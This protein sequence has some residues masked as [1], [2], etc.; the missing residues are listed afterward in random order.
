[1]N[2]KDKLIRKL[3]DTGKKHRILVYPTLALVAVISAISHAVYWGRGNGKK[4]VASIM[5]MTMLITQSLFLTSSADVGDNPTASGDASPTDAVVM[6]IEDVDVVSEPEIG[7]IIRLYRIDETGGDPIPLESIPVD[8]DNPTITIPGATELS[9]YLFGTDQTEYVNFSQVYADKDMTIPVSGAID[10]S[11][12]DVLN[13]NNGEYSLFFKATRTAY[14]FVIKDDPNGEPAIVTG[15]PHAPITIKAPATYTEGSGDL[16]PPMSYTVESS[17]SGLERFGYNFAGLYY[18][19]GV[20]CTKDGESAVININTDESNQTTVTT[21]EAFS[22]WSPIPVE[23]TFDATPVGAPVSLA[24]ADGVNDNGE[25]TFTY[26]FG[27]TINII[28]DAEIWASNEAYYLSGWKEVESDGVT[29]TGTTYA[30]GSEV[31]TSQMVADGASMNTAGTAYV[32]RRYEAI[33]TYKTIKL[34]SDSANA[35]LNEDGSLS[36]IGTYGDQ[37]SNCNITAEY[38]NGEQSAQGTKFKY[39]IANLADVSTMLQKYGLFIAVDENNGCTITGELKD[40]TDVDVSFTLTVTDENVNADSTQGGEERVSYHTVRIVS[41]PK[42]ITIN[43]SAIVDLSGNQPNKVYDGTRDISIKTEATASGTVGTDQIV[44]LLNSAATIDDA[45]AGN[46]D[47][48]V[49]VEGMKCTSVTSNPEE[50]LERYTIVTDANNQITFDDRAIVERKP[51]SVEISLA[52]GQNST[53]LFGEKTP[54][55]V[56]KVTE[57]DVA[58]LVGTDATNYAAISTEAGYMSFMEQIL[59]F[60]SWTT[61]RSIYSNKGTYSVGAHFVPDG[62]NYA[63]SVVNAPTF[64][65]TRDAGVK[66]NENSADTAN[67][68]FSTEKL[69]NGYYPGLTIT[70]CGYYDKIRPVTDGD[71]T[72]DMSKETAEAKFYSDSNS[73]SAL[74]LGDL[75]NATISFQMLNS[76]TGAISE[77][78]TISGISVDTSAPILKN[79][80]VSPYLEYFNEFSFGS[81]FHSQEIDGE[82]VSSISIKVQYEGT[83]S[84]PDKLYYYFVDEA[85]ART[86]VNIY[87]KKL[88]LNDATGYYE[89]SILIGPTVYGQLVVYASDTTGNISGESTLSVS[90]Q[91]E[92]IEDYVNDGSTMTYFEWM[93]EN[94]SADANITTKNLIGEIASVSTEESKVWYNGLQLE[95]VATDDLEVDSGVNRIEWTV[96]K[97]DGTSY[98]VTENAGDVVASVL[99]IEDYGKIRSYMFTHTIQGEELPV[100]YYTISAVVYDNAGNSS[101]IDAVGPYLV[102]SQKPVITD[103]TDIGTESYLSGVTFEFTVS[104]DEAETVED[105]DN[106]G[107][108]GIQ[109]VTLYK[110]DA[111]GLTELRT[112]GVLDEYAYNITVNGTYVVEACDVAGNIATYEKTFNGISDTPPETPTITVEGTQGRNGWYIGNKPYIT[113]N[114]TIDIDGIPVVTKYSTE[115]GN[116]YIQDGFTNDYYEFQLEQEGEVTVSAWAVSASGVTSVETD[117]EVVK[118]DL[119]APEVYI[120]E[121]AVLEDGSMTV[122][123]RATD[124]VSGVDSTRVLLNDLPLDVTVED[125][126]LSGNFTAYEG[127]TYTITVEDIAGNVSEPL[128]FAPLSLVEYPVTD[129]TTSGAYLEAE[130]HIGTYPV[131][132]CYIAYKKATDADYTAALF[133]KVETEYG[134]DL[135]C[136]FR[137][138]E[139]DTVYDYKIYVKTDVSGEV[140]TIEG[141]FKTSSKTAT[142]VIYGSA[143]YDAN[144]ANVNAE[145][146]IYVSLYEANTIIASEK[147][148]NNTETTYMFKNVPNGSYRVVATDG[149][150]T[151]TS[152]VTVE[153]GGIVYPTDYV[154]TDG[155][156][157]VLNGKSTS[158]VIEDDSINITADELESIYDN[159]LYEGIITAEDE[160][161]LAAGGS[162]NVTLYASYMDVSDVSDAEM[163]VFDTKISDSAII[164]RYIQLYVVKEVRDYDGDLVNNTPALV[165]ELYY[166][167]TISFPL[168]DLAGEEIYVASVHGTGNSYVFKDWKNADD[169]TLSTNYVTITTRYF[170]VYALYRT[171]EKPTTYTVKWIDGDGKVMKTETVESGKAATPPAETPTKKATEKYTYKFS[172]WDKDY[173]CITTDTVISAWFTAHEIEPEEPDEPT[174]EEPD[175]PTTE[176]PD[177]PTTE[178]TDT[179]TTEEPPKDADVDDTGT[180]EPQY[181]YMGSADSPKT[182]DATPIVILILAMVMSSA[183]MIIFKKKFEE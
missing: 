95:V 125:G 85:G 169:V 38:I 84:S 1:M 76:T 128:E 15:T 147:L 116:K 131:S 17:Y 112:W 120:V 29:A 87:E 163:S 63:V 71:I 11:T 91:K 150:Y 126:V 78:V 94:S 119:D 55:Y 49:T 143:V 151:K 33:W 132:D 148:N 50:I 67:Y 70:P 178:D 22:H 165:P 20:Y 34:A 36:I 51:I 16:Y 157:F 153:N 180:Q 45:N 145:Y 53:V 43:P 41:N 139:T 19:G 4:L 9:S 155:I 121:S 28:A 118:V 123:F 97:A 130:V 58:K 108:S 90:D 31:N 14:P 12:S 122:N 72:S 6:N 129:I 164:E 66:Y 100:G 93:I 35:S 174:T 75:D 3:L 175:K 105:T 37:I 5:V 57:S 135:N 79:F 42:T 166:P 56:V 99:N 111:E 182:G 167:I 82:F 7:S 156:N 46:R 154:D 26:D 44:V 114:S 80:I 115:V 47:L 39:F 88:V 159:A 62:K 86:D 101:E 140:R 68:K 170:S 137:N 107:V 142:A 152:A 136:T 61:S 65:V 74:V 158:V 172:K 103:N 179:P 96:T 110:K 173:S 176:E 83:G 160:A 177:K 23:V 134:M 60:N 40:I 104:D 141:S 73:G 18:N 117:V 21:I 106:S 168:G 89:A 2:L 64:T 54:D 32:G 25:Q 27:E 98:T 102:D 146:P 181:G 162:I 24:V 10:L 81:Y 124:S 171:V 113:I 52:E 133:N 109:T 59:G 48:T 183:G 69:S 8:T 13:P 149:F 127:E 161:V 92:K 30:A 138:L 77:I 144:D